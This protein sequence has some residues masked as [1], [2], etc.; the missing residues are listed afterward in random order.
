MGSVS[1]L[2]VWETVEWPDLQAR[3]DY[4]LK[5]VNGGPKAEKMIFQLSPMPEEGTDDRIT[6]AV[7]EGIITA[8]GC[9]DL[10]FNETV[11]FHFCEADG[12]ANF[13]RTLIRVYQFAAN[14][15]PNADQKSFGFQIA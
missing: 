6:D 14:T 15:L 7:A 12:L 13:A 5:D 4:Q 10:D 1:S 8:N 3:L 2:K 9:M 11:K